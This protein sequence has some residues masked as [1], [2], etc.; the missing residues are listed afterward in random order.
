M[1]TTRSALG[2]D[3]K[4]RGLHEVFET[5]PRVLQWTPEAERM[6]SHTQQVNAKSFLILYARALVLC[7]REVCVSAW[8]TERGEGL[9][10]GRLAVCPPW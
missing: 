5:V 10:S 7:V 1:A 2:L 8:I 3:G 9:T 4:Q 6:Q